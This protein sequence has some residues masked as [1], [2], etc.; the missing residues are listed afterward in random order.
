VRRACD[1]VR[2]A[3][4][5]RAA[6]RR[7]A[8]VGP[9]CQPASQPARKDR[10]SAGGLSP[11][12]FRCIQSG[13][14][15]FAECLPGSRCGLVAPRRPPAHLPPWSCTRNDD[16]PV[17]RT[18]RAR[19]QVAPLCSPQQCRHRRNAPGDLGE[20]G[21]LAAARMLREIIA[22]LLSRLLVLASLLIHSGTRE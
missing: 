16:S 7:A 12:R 1:R 13:T 11:R 10:S 6:S 8:R 17:T 2:P 22:V 18:A 20:P 4:G 14:C 5:Y 9:V 19:R 15:T 3:R 21:S